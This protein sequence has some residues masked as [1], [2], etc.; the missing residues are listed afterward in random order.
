MLG[1]WR[2]VQRRVATTRSLHEALGPSRRAVHEKTFRQYVVSLQD[3]LGTDAK[4]NV[5]QSA[6]TWWPAEAWREALGP[7]FRDTHTQLAH[8]LQQDGPTNHYHL[9]RRHPELAAHVLTVILDAT[10]SFPYVHALHRDMDIIKV[11]RQMAM[12]IGEDKMVHAANTVLHQRSL[13]RDAAKCTPCLY[14]S[15]CAASDSVSAPQLRDLLRHLIHHKL[16]PEILQLIDFATINRIPID[17]WSRIFGAFART[18]DVAASLDDASVDQLA[19]AFMAHYHAKPF[20]KSEILATSMVR[21]AIQRGEV[22]TAIACHEFL[23]SHGFP[24]NDAT[25]VQMLELVRPQDSNKYGNMEAFQAYFADSVAARGGAA[26][27]RAILS[28]AI[29]TARDAK[30]TAFLRQILASVR[31]NPALDIGL[32]NTAL[33]YLVKSN[34]AQDH[35]LARTLV[36]DMHAAGGSVRPNRRTLMLLLRVTRS[37][38]SAILVEL[39]RM[40]PTLVKSVSKTNARVPDIA[41]AAFI[42][43]VD[44]IKGGDMTTAAAVRDAML[45]DPTGSDIPFDKA[46]WHRMLATMLQTRSTFGAIVSWLDLCDPSLDGVFYASWFTYAQ[47]YTEPL[48]G[49]KRVLRRWLQLDDARDVDKFQLAIVTACKVDDVEMAT[50]MWAWMRTSGHTPPPTAAAAMLN[51]YDRNGLDTFAFFRRELQEPHPDSLTRPVLEKAL[52]LSS[53][54]KTQTDF[55]RD[56]L[57]L[58]VQTMQPEDWTFSLYRRALRSCAADTAVAAKLGME[59]VDLFTCKRLSF[60]PHDKNCLFDSLRIAKRG[61]LDDQCAVLEAYS[62]LN[63]WPAVSSYTTMMEHLVENQSPSAHAATILEMMATQGIA[64]DNKFATLYAMLLVRN[65]DLPNVLALVRLMVA[66]GVAPTDYFFTAIFSELNALA[67]IDTCFEFAASV[68]SI[69]HFEAL[70]VGLIQAGLERG[71]VE[72]VCNVAVQMECEGCV[73][74]STTLV[75]IIDAVQSTREMEKVVTVVAQLMEGGP[76]PNPFPPQVYHALWA[77]LG[78]FKSSNKMALNFIRAQAAAQGC[79]LAPPQDIK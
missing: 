22:D 50:D 24:I 39:A 35:I 32:F 44:L 70:Y 36:D 9:L 10:Q 48:V 42:S 40:G 37:D 71:V 2:Q 52:F 11:L 62:E 19:T 79:D 76:R 58:L 55:C 64:V 57:T 53:Q 68:A 63:L 74:P 69:R 7:A 72:R 46:M 20:A 60:E 75:Q 47:K 31:G 23:Q 43:I 25:T 49:G 59:L 45:L 54:R 30:D 21:A 66:Q 34:D 5:W 73:V 3:L 41:H 26:Q 65:Q 15:V 13:H 4:Q 6:I 16:L 29:H 78:R 67:D 12:A 8:K 18:H 17:V 28:V 1:R 77:Q 61:T 14:R 38:P 56:V 27:S 33:A 51:L